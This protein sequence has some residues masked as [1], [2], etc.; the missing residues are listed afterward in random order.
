MLENNEKSFYGTTTIG[1]KGQVVIPAKA[2]ESMKIKKGE[3][4]L[5]FGISRDMVV[6][7]KLSNLEKFASHLSKRL[8]ALKEI[9][10]KTNAK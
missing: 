6:L 3:K 9:I 2:R 7:S 8:L 4:L 1:G 10:R 5:V